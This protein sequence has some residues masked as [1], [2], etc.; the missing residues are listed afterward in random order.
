MPPAAKPMN[1]LAHRE[2][3]DDGITA[4]FDETVKRDGVAGSDETSHIGAKAG[5]VHPR[6]QVEL[7]CQ[8]LTRPA[9]RAVAR[10]E[11]VSFGTRGRNTRGVSDELLRSFVG[12]ETRRHAE[13]GC[14]ARAPENSALSNVPSAHWY[15]VSSK[16]F[17]STSQRSAGTP[18]SVSRPE[19][20]PG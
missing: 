11:K 15:W 7:C 6:T 14:V 19:P 3:F 10:N 8:A 18:Y 4:R 2:S 17:G 5:E 1:G 16:P 13:H 9:F 12:V 20:R